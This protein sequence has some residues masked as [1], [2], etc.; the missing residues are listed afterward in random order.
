MLPVSTV[1]VQSVTATGQVTRVRTRYPVRKS[2]RSW[3][4]GRSK[5]LS[6]LLSD[7]VLVDY[8]WL[9]TCGIASQRDP[10]VR[11]T[12]TPQKR[13][14]KSPDDPR[15]YSLKF[16]LLKIKRCIAWEVSATPREC[17]FAN[18]VFS[19]HF[20]G[21]LQTVAIVDPFNMQV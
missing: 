13:P 20:F 12:A 19:S 4:S 3:N 2:S 11:F 21:F 17:W 7:T 6:L 14:R 18:S 15:S 10:V 5:T 8:R 9:N 16:L 1:D